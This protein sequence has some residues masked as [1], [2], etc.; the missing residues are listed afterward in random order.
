MR[1]IASEDLEAPIFAPDVAFEIQS[2]D[3]NLDDIEDKIRV[4]RARGTHAVVVIDP[5]CRFV[6]VIDDDGVR[7]LQRDD[8]FEHAALPDFRLELAERFSALDLPV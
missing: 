6:R 8:V 5:R 3:D 7:A 2:P 1:G 4:D